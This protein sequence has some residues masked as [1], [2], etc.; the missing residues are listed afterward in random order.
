LGVRV[1]FSPARGPGAFWYG[2]ARAIAFR[3]DGREFAV[4]CGGAVAIFP[5]T[6]LPAE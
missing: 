1:V 3:T 6:A 5:L 2:G 4:A